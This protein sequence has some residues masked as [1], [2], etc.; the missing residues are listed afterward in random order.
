MFG[1]RVPRAHTR[2][3]QR[4]PRAPAEQLRLRT[5]QALLRANQRQTAGFTWSP[6]HTRPGHTLPR[7]GD[8]SH[9]KR[10]SRHERVWRRARLCSCHVAWVTEDRVRPSPFPHAPHVALAGCDEAQPACTSS[11]S[12]CSCFTSPRRS[13]PGELVLTP[14]PP[15]PQLCPPRPSCSGPASHPL[16]PFAT[17]SCRLFT[18][19]SCELVTSRAWVSPVAPTLEERLTGCAKVHSRPTCLDGHLVLTA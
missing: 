8:R 7:G 5:L 11:A 10:E 15:R 17:A 9:V 13:E 12:C 16:S 6:L 4:S 18:R 19:Q 2:S 14:W 3:G 1:K